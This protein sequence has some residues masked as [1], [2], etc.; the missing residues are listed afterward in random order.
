MRVRG[1]AVAPRLIAP[2]SY[3]TAALNTENSLNIT[4]GFE[5]IPMGHFGWNGS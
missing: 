4:I 2:D 5:H 1:L 3:P